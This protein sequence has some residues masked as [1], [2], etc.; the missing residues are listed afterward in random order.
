MTPR[1]RISLP[2][3]VLLVGVG[4]T[5]AAREQSLSV[6][7]TGLILGSISGVQTHLEEATADGGELGGF[8]DLEYEV[9]V[10]RH[11]AVAIRLDG[12]VFNYY[13]RYFRGDIKGGG[14][15][16]GFSVR[17]FTDAD[18]LAGWFFGAGADS[19]GIGQEVMRNYSF[20]GGT[21]VERQSSLVAALA[22]H[23]QTG[24][25]FRPS[26]HFSIEASL[27]MGAAVIGR[28][29]WWGGASAWVD[30]II[31]PAITIGWVF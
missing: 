15:G 6:N 13:S 14:G 16:L 22:G 28:S 29:S 4:R 2:L 20:W 7:P 8:T 27:Y 5:G 1:R 24:Y 23:F 31:L 19:L 25:V 17:Y 18:T 3:L 9:S 11:V 10:S 21:F 12:T 30:P 26:D